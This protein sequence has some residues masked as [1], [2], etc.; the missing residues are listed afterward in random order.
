MAW[1]WLGRGL[2]QETNN[3]ASSSSSVNHRNRPYSNL[4]SRNKLL[5][6]APA[7]SSSLSYSRSDVSSGNQRSRTP[8]PVQRQ[9]GGV[10]GAVSTGGAGGAAAEAI[11]G[12]G[13]GGSEVAHN[14][15]GG[16]AK[17]STSSLTTGA[18]GRVERH[19]AG[20]RVM[21]TWVS[22]KEHVKS[23]GNSWRDK[24]CHHRLNEGRSRH[25]Q[26]R[27]I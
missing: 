12:G 4:G 5:A 9:G 24:F 13:G 17:A 22:G 10:Q 15:G 6:T 19:G 2:W 11:C 3:G 23:L 7:S 1:A 20:L 21:V 16:T 27:N 26:N 18:A 14:G 8:P 25:V